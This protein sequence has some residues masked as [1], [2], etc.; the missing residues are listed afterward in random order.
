MN[1]NT[2]GDLSRSQ[3]QHQLE[4]RKKKFV[5]CDVKSRENSYEKKLSLSHNNN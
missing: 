3:T 4:E 5:Q 1:N 2:Q